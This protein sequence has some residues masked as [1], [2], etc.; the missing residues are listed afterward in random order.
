MQ[1]FTFSIFSQ[2]FL[3]KALFQFV[4]KFVVSFHP[5][6]YYISFL[7]QPWEKCMLDVIRARQH[8]WNGCTY[9]ALLKIIGITSADFQSSRWNDENVQWIRNTTVNA[10]V[11]WYLI[12]CAF[13][14]RLYNL[15][16]AKNTRRGVLLLVKLQ[17]YEK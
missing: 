11:P 9:F 13:W 7:I 12:L 16:N 4:L 17:L 15:K 8:K 10:S 14:Y 1:I 2:I 5:R 3:A 6:K